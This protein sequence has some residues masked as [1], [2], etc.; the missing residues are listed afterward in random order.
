MPHLVTDVA[1]HRATILAKALVETVSDLR[2]IEPSDIIGHIRRRRW[3]AI[4]DLVHSSAEL[5]FR[6]GAL[7]FACAADF[8]LDW[9]SNPSVALEMEFQGDSISAF[10]TLFLERHEGV[11]ALRHVWFAREP[12]TLIE[13]TAALADAIADARLGHGSI[14]PLPMRHR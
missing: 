1:R 11:V 3:A 4:A 8:P 6:E 2:L 12:T 9:V 10:F 14:A 5:Y 13:G 7:T